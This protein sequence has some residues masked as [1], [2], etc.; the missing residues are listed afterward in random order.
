MDMHMQ[1]HMKMQIKIMHLQRGDRVSRSRQA[2]WELF[3]IPFPAQGYLGSEGVLTPL[4]QPA[5]ISNMGLRR[6]LQPSVIE[7]E[8]L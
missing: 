2:L 8:L 1:L 5:L 3:G 6:T 4:L 7:T